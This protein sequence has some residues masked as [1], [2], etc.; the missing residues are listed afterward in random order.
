MKTL[1]ITASNRNRLDLSKNITKFFIKS[2]ENQT[3][4][5]FEVL[6]ADGGSDNYE[7]LKEYFESRECEP[8][9]R[10]VQEPLGEKFE[11]AKLN[12]VGV[13][14]ANTEYI[15]TTDVDMF[16]APLFV[17]E[18]FKR[19]APDV[20]VESRTMYWK[21]RLTGKIYRG[22]LDPFNDIESCKIGRIKKRSTAGG[23]QCAHIDQWNKVRGFD[24]EFVGWG[25]EDFDLLTRMQRSGARVKWMGEGRDVINLFH[26]HHSKPNIAED[27]AC[28]KQNIKLLNRAMRGKRPYTANPNG[29]GGIYEDPAV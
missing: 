14:N 21:G 16:F 9:I 28:Q 29:W 6:I 2:L 8:L 13:R 3:C 19:I 17:E 5:D 15:M 23:C 18:L 11:R 22:E 24:E 4:K 27:L 10:I 7:E 1:T 20:F 26:Q 25:S 12:N